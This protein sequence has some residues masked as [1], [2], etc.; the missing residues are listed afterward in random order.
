MMCYTQD[1]SILAEPDSTE[2]DKDIQDIKAAKR[3]P[4]ETIQ[5]TQPLDQ[6][7][8]ALK[9]SEATKAKNIPAPSS[10]CYGA[11]SMNHS[12]ITQSWESSLFRERF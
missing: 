2:I 3:R 8:E 11:N 10:N 12:I 4:D 9:V 5:L 7:L 6:V 1:D